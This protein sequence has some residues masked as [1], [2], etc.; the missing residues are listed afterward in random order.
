[1]NQM[2]KRGSGWA[3]LF[4]GGIQSTAT[5]A[6]DGRNC[7][8]IKRLGPPWHGGYVWVMNASICPTAAAGSV[9]VADIDDALATLQV[10]TYDAQA[11]LRAESR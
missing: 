4:I 8:A 2:T 6:N 9:R 7:L 3:N 11:N 5:F 1:M 10:R